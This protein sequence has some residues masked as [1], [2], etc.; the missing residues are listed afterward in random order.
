MHPPSIAVLVDEAL[1]DGH[2]LD[3]LVELAPHEAGAERPVVAHHL[4]AA[5]DVLVLRHRVEVGGTDGV[6]RPAPSRPSRGSQLDELAETGRIPEL[7]GAGARRQH[8]PVEVVVL[9]TGQ[10]DVGV[11]RD[12]QVVLAEA[13]EQLGPALAARIP[14]QA[15]TRRVLVVDLDEGLAV[16]VLVLVLLPADAEVEG[17][18][19]TTTAQLSWT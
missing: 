6:A 18:P 13:G 15:E 5:D 14:D 8:V 10:P 9:E 1:V 12:R 2:V 7:V 4:L 17:Q 16:G 3:D 11:G 19:S